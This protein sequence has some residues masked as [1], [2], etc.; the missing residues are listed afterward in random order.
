MILTPDSRGTGVEGFK[1]V[2]WPILPCHSE[3]VTEAAFA[4]ILCIISVF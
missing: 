1:A 2:G 3:K 4:G